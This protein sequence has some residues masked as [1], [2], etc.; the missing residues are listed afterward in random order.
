MPSPLAW[1]RIPTRR[2]LSVAGFELRFLCFIT[3]LF[4]VVSCLQGAQPALTRVDEIRALP[5]EDSITTNLVHLSGVITYHDDEWSASFFSDDT[6]GIFLQFPGQTEKFEA[7]EH[8]EIDGSV[9]KGG[10]APT[11]VV[12]SVRRLGRKSF[13]TPKRLPLDQLLRGS[14]DCQWIELDGVIHRTF[15]D[16]A[17]LMLQLGYPARDI[18]VAIPTSSVRGVSIDKLVD[19]EVRLRGVCG[20]TYTQNSWRPG[21]LQ[22]EGFRLLMPDLS[23]LEVRRPAPAAP[24]DLPEQRIDRVMAF[25][26]SQEWTHRVR[27]RG[28]ITLKRSDGVWFLQAGDLG[29]RVISSTPPSAPVGAEVEVAGFPKVLPSG[30]LLEHALVKDSGRLQV[31]TP[32]ATSTNFFVG[33]QAGLLVSATGV[34]VDWSRQGRDSILELRANGNPFQ[35]IFDSSQLPPKWLENLPAGSTLRISGVNSVPY[36]ELRRPTRLQLYAQDAGSV[37]VVKRGPWL[38]QARLRNGLVIVGGCAL[39]ALVWVVLLR[40]QVRLQTRQIRRQFE[41]RAAIERRFQDLAENAN[42]LIYTLSPEGVLTSV[43]QVAERLT[44]FSRE[45]LAGMFFRDLVMEEHR[46][47]LDAYLQTNL[48]GST[49]RGRVELD[50]LS[51]EGRRLTLEL[52]S[53]GSFTSGILSEIQGVARDITDRKRAEEA[54]KA[55]E[56]LLKSLAQGTSST[57]GAVFFERL[58][59]DLASAFSVRFVEVSVLGGAENTLLRSLVTCRDGLCVDGVIRPVSGSLGEEVLS[60]SVVSHAERVRELYPM[61]SLLQELHAEGCVCVAIRTTASA[62]RGLLTLI[63]DKPLADVERI[64]ALLQIF[65]GRAGVELERLQFETSL[66]EREQRYRSLVSSLVVGVTLQ[67]PQ[68]RVIE[69]NDSA[70]R[71]LGLTRDEFLGRSIASPLWQTVREDGSVF[72]PEEYPSMSTAL[73]GVPRHNVVMGVYRSPGDLRWISI[74]SQAVFESDGVTVAASVASFEDITEVRL[75][76]QALKSSEERYR[77]LVENSTDV[78]CELD[79]DGR[80]VY[81]SPNVHALLGCHHEDLMRQSPVEHLHPDESDRIRQLFRTPSSTATHRF[82]HTNGSWVWFETTARWFTTSAGEQRL[83]LVSRDISRRVA[84]QQA[85]AALEVRLRQSQK[86]EAIGTLAGGI[87]HDFNNI[88]GGILSNTELVQSSLPPSHPV[89][90]QLAQIVRAILRARDVVR[91]L[92]TFSRKKEEARQS[93]HL[94]TVIGEA[95]DLL[96]SALPSTTEIESDLGQASIHVLA[97]PSQLH[98]IV[99]NLGVNASHAMPSGGLLRVECDEVEIRPE[100]AARHSQLR[101]GLFARILFMDQGHGMRPETVE[102]IFEPFFTTKGVG[103]GTGLGLSVVHGVVNSHEGM[104]LVNSAPGQ[105]TTFQVLLPR[106]L[107]SDTGSFYGS[108]DRSRVLGEPVMYVDENPLAADFAET[109][110][111]RLGCQASVFTS[112]KEALELFR[113]NPWKFDVLILAS[114]LTTMDRERFCDEVR[115][116]RANMPLLH[117]LPHGYLKTHQPAASLHPFEKVVVTPF[118]LSRLSDALQQVRRGRGQNVSMHS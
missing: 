118:S 29:I 39:C 21:D 37:E 46:S 24:F 4:V 106:K 61:D 82:R 63:H 10:F 80:F 67:D 79:L 55:S 34:L 53:R 91:Q 6:A 86:L 3:V 104:I 92:L 42:D 117:A 110:L 84:D 115:L 25:H 41:E 48:K 78:L 60:A 99:M 113:S 45:R 96:R 65:A 35:V 38:N 33:A 54:V 22:P 89:Q 116:L 56:A 47:R 11:V 107:G 58:A 8:V 2:R 68:G 111:L 73:T 64:Q 108:L 70:C 85:H 71:I 12:Q 103:E 31:L 5:R 30:P 49:D 17:H 105:G 101:P 90:A 66:R 50:I 13:P 43:N 98:Q 57:W 28:V 40:R 62:P 69:V 1:S 97:Q 102:R 109:Q 88:M 94:Q 19:S 44:G 15:V 81:V 9:G 77:L 112:P 7:G 23:H 16:G 72:P 95:L 76:S 74:N 14:Q 32:I 26:P 100:V 51:A 18:M 114:P 87:A 83:A 59:T 20:T 75:A 36:D 27:T 93:V 52:S